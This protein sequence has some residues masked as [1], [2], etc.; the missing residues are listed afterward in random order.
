VNDP[1]LPHWL[2]VN[3]GMAQNI[4]G[5]SYL[6]RQTGTHG[7]IKDWEFYLSKDGV[8]WGTPVKKGTFPDGTA[9]QKVTF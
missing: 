3:L 8:D 5:F 4:A 1:K 2:I 6:P 7:R 9:V